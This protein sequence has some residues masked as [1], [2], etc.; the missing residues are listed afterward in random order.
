MDT[1]VLRAKI[2]RM[3]DLGVTL[4]KERQR[5]GEDLLARCQRVY[6]DQSALLE[7]IMGEFKS[8]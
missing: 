2:L 4:E 3:S 5:K 1:K 6:D 8:S 7:E